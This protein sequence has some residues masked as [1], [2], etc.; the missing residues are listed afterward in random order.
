MGNG[1][2][3][4]MGSRPRPE[5]GSRFLRENLRALGPFDQPLI[6]GETVLLRPPAGPVHCIDQI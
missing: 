5:R 6:I 3:L 4:G 1:G 2:L